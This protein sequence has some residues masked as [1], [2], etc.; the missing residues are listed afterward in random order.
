MAA[1][2]QSG[3]PNVYPVLLESL[4][5]SAAVLNPL[6]AVEALSR[7]SIEPVGS[8]MDDR[9]LRCLPRPDTLYY[10]TVSL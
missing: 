5:G 9:M 4:A 1:S 7:E 3:V 6:I 10:V 8:L 2:P